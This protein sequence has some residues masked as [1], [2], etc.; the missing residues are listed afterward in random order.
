MI[1]LAGIATMLQPMVISNVEAITIL[2]DEV[3]QSETKESQTD[4]ESS[5]SDELS[6]SD[7]EVATSELPELSI[8]ET[9]STVV[10]SSEIE[11]E[12]SEVKTEETEETE[13]SEDEIDAFA[14]ARPEKSKE[15][16]IDALPSDVVPVDG[17]FD[18][19]ALIEG[20]NTAYVEKT[21]SGGD[22]VFMT[23]ASKTV[24]DDD[25]KS[26]GKSSAMW[27]HE[28]AR[29]DMRKAFSTEMYVYLGNASLKAA[30]G[31]TF[32]FQADDRGTSSI[33]KTGGAMGVYGNMDGYREK[34]KDKSV[35]EAF[36][37]EGVQKSFSVEMDT[38]KNETFDSGVSGKRQHISAAYPAHEKFANFTEKK[39]LPWSKKKWYRDEAVV[40]Y[41]TK[42]KLDWFTWKYTP[43]L[44]STAVAPL[45]YQSSNTSDS[46][47]FN[48]NH[49]LADGSW[50]TLKVEYTPKDRVAGGEYSVDAPDFKIT[51]DGKI[52]DLSGK[53]SPFQ[54]GLVTKEQPFMHWG[55]T[56]ATG[57]NAA[58][59][60]VAFKNIPKTAGIDHEADIKKDGESII[61]GED[62]AIVHSADVLT[63]ET[64]SHYNQ[65]EVDFVSP[66]FV[67]TINENVELVEGSFEVK[68]NGSQEFVKVPTD[69]YKVENGQLVYN[70]SQNL[71]VNNRD[72]DTKFDV[73]VK[74]SYYKEL[75]SEESQIQSTTEHV[76]STQEL[77]YIIEP[78]EVDGE[79]VLDEMTDNPEITNKVTGKIKINTDFADRTVKL[80]LNGDPQ[81]NDVKA[82]DV[83]LDGN[84]E[85]TFEVPF[86]KYLTAENT[87]K[88]TVTYKGE[89]VEEAVVAVGKG[90][91][92]D[93]TAPEADP[94][95]MDYFKLDKE[96]KTLPFTAMQLLENITDTNPHLV[97]RDGETPDISAEFTNE[98]EIKKALTKIGEV[99]AKI[100][101]KDKYENSREITS[102]VIVHENRI[103]IEAAD[104]TVYLSDIAN[105]EN[106]T[107]VLKTEKEIKDIIE[108]ESEIKVKYIDLGGNKI[109]LGSEEFVAG[110]NDKNT[111]ELSSELKPEIGVYGFDLNVHYTIHDPVEGKDDNLVPMDNNTSF[112]VTVIDGKLSLTGEGD[113][114]TVN[115]ITTKVEDISLKNLLKISVA[116]THFETDSW[117]LE[118][119]AST[120][121]NSKGNAGFP[122]SLIYLGK[123]VPEPAENE[124][125]GLDLNQ[126]PV[127]I[128]SSRE[129][130]KDFLLSEDA[131]SDN[132]LRVRTTDATSK[133]AEADETYDTTITW[134][135]SGSSDTAVD[136]ADKLTRKGK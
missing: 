85:A 119:E 127:V 18:T 24:V 97:T 73:K 76:T 48:E 2:K 112:E 133:W 9:E 52:K 113:L 1:V 81:I 10:E 43:L 111:Y 123:G 23:D 64:Q 120:F 99:D 38:N 68:E 35:L 56:A 60:A 55:M 47:W 91:V 63:Y 16:I 101:L 36:I 51:F 27:S 83:K 131:G 102:K 95:T 116:N 42:S 79:V 61:H 14:K 19:E 74:P 71:S 104:S 26:L 25:G 37:S 84:G 90:D 13:E 28:F 5:T 132:Y 78:L 40:Q 80:K 7:S 12:A 21:P 77:A 108:N 8:S 62:Y 122:L 109:E 58:T 11:T 50:H 124:K 22:V 136:I 75:V 34:P 41:K 57:S 110:N 126:G 121:T 54:N 17:I 96:P 65:G 130:A 31:M 66:V 98:A 94:L 15:E 30:D 33:G 46:G 115:K 49:W 6:S 72:F 29:V 53:F 105:R 135:L 93:K 89:E 20:S 4:E 67:E 82:I 92:I 118:A 86:E 87:I 125:P 103:L 45:L 117:V 70:L 88:S 69:Q 44:Q 134:T 129:R 39:V 3:D 32:T 114:S 100:I 128:D 106:G 107:N 59:Q